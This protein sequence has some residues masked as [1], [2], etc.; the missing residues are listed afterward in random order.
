LRRHS[1]Q[2]GQRVEALVQLDRQLGDRRFGLPKDVF[3][4]VDVELGGGA[5]LIF[6]P[7]D[8]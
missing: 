4:L 2:D 3:C 5:A 6:R 1:K 7:R 8:L